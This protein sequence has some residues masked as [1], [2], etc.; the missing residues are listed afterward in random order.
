MDAEGYYGHN[1]ECRLRRNGVSDWLNDRGMPLGADEHDASSSAELRR[2]MD[3]IGPERMQP[4][5][6][7]ARPGRRPPAYAPTPQALSKVPWPR[8][9]RGPADSGDDDAYDVNAGDVA[10]EDERDPT[11]VSISQ[12]LAYIRPLWARARF[13]SAWL[14]RFG[15]PVLYGLGLLVMVSSLGLAGLIARGALEAK[16]SGSP[17]TAIDGIPGSTNGLRAPQSTPSAPTAVATEETPTVGNGPSPTPTTVTPVPYLVGQLSFYNSSDRAFDG[18]VTVYSQAVMVAAIQPTCRNMPWQLHVA[19]HDTVV[20]CCVITGTQGRDPPPAIEAHGFQQTY[21]L[22]GQPDLVVDNA[23]Q[24]LRT[25]GDPAGA[26]QG[27][28]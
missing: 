5:K 25:S 17:S 16:G 24:W 6:G 11:S 2:M 21:S 19:A 18:A 9:T 23:Q 7:R 8:V 26:C 4:M 12:A 28:P 13:D 15:K 20:R 3:D 14:D 22:S 27:Q 1:R 10:D